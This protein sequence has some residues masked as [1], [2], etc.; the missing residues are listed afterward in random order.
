MFALVALA[1][2]VLAGWAAYTRST[3]RLSHVEIQ[4]PDGSFFRTEA[5]DFLR[6]IE[7]W[8]HSIEGPSLEQ[9][10]L[11]LTG[12]WNENGLRQPDYEV[13][14]VYGN[15][16]RKEISVWVYAED[17]VPVHLGRW[18]GTS[19][20]KGYSCLARSEPFTAFAHLRR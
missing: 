14:L 4:R 16:W 3:H 1:V 20:G 2:L 17:Y 12:R 11:R 13:T 8:Y 15:G 9:R 6:Q 7:A 10:V 5:P 19:G 18:S